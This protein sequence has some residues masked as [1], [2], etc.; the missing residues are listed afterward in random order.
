MIPL[1]N[2]LEGLSR[3][4]I[5]SLVGSL[6]SLHHII[7]LEPG[8]RRAT[9]I[10][11]QSEVRPAIHPGD[12]R[13]AYGSTHG[14]E[15]L[16][17]YTPPFAVRS[18][19]DSALMNGSTSQG[20][21]IRLV[22]L[23][24]EAIFRQR[25]TDAYIPHAP[26]SGVSERFPFADHAG[27]VRSPDTLASGTLHTSH[28]RIIG[29]EDVVHT[30]DFIYMMSLSHCVTFRNHHL[31][32]SLYRTTE[33]R[34]QLRHGHIA[35]FMHGIHLSVII[36]EHGEVVDIAI[37]L[38][39]RPRSLSTVRD[40]NLQTMSVDIRED[41]ELA[42]VIAD[43]RCPDTLSIRFLPV[44][45]IEVIRIIESVEA[46]GREFPVHEIF[47]ME[48]HQYRHAMHRGTRQI[49]ILPHSDDIR[50]RELIIKQRVGKG[51]IPV[52]SRP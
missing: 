25:T 35:V 16:H 38:M 6:R 43:G 42:V 32:A 49:I 31:A 37:D 20:N 52:I 34:F 3:E 21:S 48:H 1:P 33:V 46:V 50:I 36:E 29:R 14:I 28:R 51:T 12:R 8:T 41:I 47:G 17:R 30:I 10:L 24:L 11:L 4:I 9:E 5:T 39:M 44:S 23:E 27:F 26:S 15:I 45:E 19:H 2:R 22:V 18:L 7:R 13:K 40:I